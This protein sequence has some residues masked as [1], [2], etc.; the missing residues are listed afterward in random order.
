M[1]RIDDVRIG[2]GAVVVVSVLGREYP[3]MHDARGSCCKQELTYEHSVKSAPWRNTLIP[4]Y[5]YVRLVGRRLPPWAQV[6]GWHSQMVWRDLMHILYLGV[7]PDVAASLIWDLFLDG[8]LESA[9]PVVALKALYMQLERRCLSG[10]FQESRAKPNGKL[11][12]HSI[13]HGPNVMVPK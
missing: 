7:G 1:P 4:H 9:D 13:V 10:C 8:L 3:R 2:H 12:R 5:T 6:P 11:D